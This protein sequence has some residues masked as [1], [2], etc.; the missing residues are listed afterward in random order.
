MPLLAVL[1]LG[2]IL[3]SGLVALRQ[4]D[5]NLLLGNSSVAHMGFIFLGIASL[6][7][8]GLTGALFIMIAHGFLAALAFGLSGRLYQ[9]TRT[10][11]MSALGGLSRVVPFLATALI[12]AMLAGCGLPGFANFVG[13]ALVFFGAWKVYPTVTVL[14]VWGGLVIGAIYMI[15]AVRC[16]CHGPLP[17][18]WAELVDAADPWRRLPFV[19]LLAGLLVF[20]F[21]PRGL[22]EKIQPA[23]AVILRVSE[24]SAAGMA[25]GRVGPLSAVPA[26]GRSRG[27]APQPGLAGLEPLFSP[28]GDWGAVPR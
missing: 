7:L 28:R 22:T 6:N 15:R 14:A 19:A 21:W 2:N 8:L 4:R 13:E 20:G 11:E 3:Y 26:N 23:A 1:C 12:L 25:A 10:L 9:Q 17:N 5:L 16:I 27:L 24:A 18:Q